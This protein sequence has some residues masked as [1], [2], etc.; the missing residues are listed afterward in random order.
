MTKFTKKELLNVQLPIILL[1]GNDTFSIDEILSKLISNLMKN[2]NDRS[3]YIY[4]DADDKE[5]SQMSIVDAASQCSMLTENRI[6]V[7]RRFNK[8]FE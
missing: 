8:L 1:Y 5:C 6:V 4:L 3:E 2:G 7:V